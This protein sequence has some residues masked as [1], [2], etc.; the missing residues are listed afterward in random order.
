MKLITEKIIA[1]VGL[2][3]VCSILLVVTHGEHGIGWFICG[4]I[5]IL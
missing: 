5:F 3:I 1:L 2:L 4:L